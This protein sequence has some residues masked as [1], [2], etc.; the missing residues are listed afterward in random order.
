MVRAAVSASR[1]HSS[2]RAQLRP[3]VRRQNPGP[4]Q[5]NAAEKR[6]ETQEE[7]VQVARAQGTCARLRGGG[8]GPCE[9]Q[10]PN[11]RVRLA[12][13]SR[14]SC[15]L[16]SPRSAAL[17]GCRAPLRQVKVEG[18]GDKQRSSFLVGRIN[19]SHGA[20]PPNTN[21]R[22]TVRRVRGSGRQCSMHPIL[23][24]QTTARDLVCC[25]SFAH[26]R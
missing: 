24:A 8:R 9:R 4:T 23:K 10:A 26:M 25:D 21:L 15:L 17:L 1:H 20:G 14:L 3:R 18:E 12:W 5:R 11:V 7:R 22:P 2:V 16:R 13:G 6:R 19:L